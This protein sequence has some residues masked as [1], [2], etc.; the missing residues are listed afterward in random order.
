MKYPYNS[1]TNEILSFAHEELSETFSK[2]FLSLVKTGDEE[3]HSALLFLIHDALV[4][5]EKELRHKG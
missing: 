2:T 3:K 4:Y 1:T 5:I